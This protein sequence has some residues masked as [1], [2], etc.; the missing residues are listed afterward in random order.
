MYKHGNILHNRLR[1][2]RTDK[3][4]YRT[5]YTISHKKIKNAK[6]LKLIGPHENTQNIHAVHA[7]G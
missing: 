1:L 4:I 3:P 5:R 7:I 6:M 2:Q